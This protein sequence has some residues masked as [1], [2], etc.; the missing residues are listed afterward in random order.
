[1][2]LGLCVSFD[3]LRCLGVVSHES[4]SILR[5]HPPVRGYVSAYLYAG[6]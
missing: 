2:L 6:D 1:M 5:R 3:S 4:F